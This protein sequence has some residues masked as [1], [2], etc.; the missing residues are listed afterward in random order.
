MPLTYH[1][2]WE[3][4]AYEIQADRCTFHKRTRRL[5]R[6]RQEPQ[7]R[8]ALDRG[9]APATRG[10]ASE[11]TSEA[12]KAAVAASLVSRVA[13]VRPERESIQLA[14]VRGSGALSAGSV[15]SWQDL[16]LRAPRLIIA[17]NGLFTVTLV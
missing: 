2:E 11:I 13:F 4:P 10:T 9:E 14:A 15:P 8:A 1:H 3:Y 12:S 6:S 7:R 17:L 5:P 16:E